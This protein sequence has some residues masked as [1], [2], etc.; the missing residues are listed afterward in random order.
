M[1]F[2]LNFP[3]LTLCYKYRFTMY[4]HPSYKISLSRKAD[5]CS[6]VFIFSSVFLERCVAVKV[7]SLLFSLKDVLL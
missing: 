6:L 1:I 5:S 7:Y 2:A 3:R 4:S